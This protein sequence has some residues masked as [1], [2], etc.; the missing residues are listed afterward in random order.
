MRFYDTVSVLR[1]P[2]VTDPYGGE[3]L[4]WANATV[5]ATVP[6][7]VQPQSSSE[8]DVDR[9]MVVSRWK[10]F[11][12]PADLEVTDRVTYMSDTYRVEGEIGRWR[13]RGQDHH[14][15]CFLER[16]EHG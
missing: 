12:A 2:V 7:S 13:H 11:C 15:E 6:A 9:Q 1:A 8:E 3:S 5:V 16:V 10:L 4:D 14:I